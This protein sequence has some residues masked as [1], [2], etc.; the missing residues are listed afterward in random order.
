VPSFEAFGRFVEST[1][2]FEFW[3]KAV[4]MAWLPSLS[5]VLPPCLPLPQANAQQ[6]RPRFRG[7]WLQEQTRNQPLTLCTMTHLY[8]RFVT[9]LR[10]VRSPARPHHADAQRLARMGYPHR[11]MSRSVQRPG[12]FDPDIGV[13]QAVEDFC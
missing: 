11:E 1:N 6:K 4:Q 2:P 5:A 10:V 8:Y 13:G 9:G 3:A 7:Q 12:H